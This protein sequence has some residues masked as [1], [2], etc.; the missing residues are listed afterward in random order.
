VFADEFDKDYRKKE[1]Q[2]GLL[3]ILDGVFTSKKLFL[4]TANSEYAI[5][6]YMLNRPGRIHYFEKF[7]KLTEDMI[8]AI[9]DDLL[10][11]K[12]YKEELKYVCNVVGNINLNCLIAIIKECNMFEQSPKEVYPRLNVNIED[13]AYTCTFTR[14]SD[15]ASVEFVT[16]HHPLAKEYVELHRH[17]DTKFKDEDEDENDDSVLATINKA[18]RKRN[19]EDEG[20]TKYLSYR[21]SIKDCKVALDGRNITITASYG[22]YVYKPK[23]VYSYIY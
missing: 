4:F 6:D 1:D 18:R 17:S 15:K 10:E 3:P 23:N 11:N 16:D 12:D 20:Y 22:V 5:S 9:I 13:T 19:D 21:T 14:D 2:E 8:D 7:Y